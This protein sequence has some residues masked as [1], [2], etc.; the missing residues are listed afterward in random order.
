MK[1]SN[2]V[3][4][5][6]GAGA[7]G[8]DA[9]VNLVGIYLMFYLTDVLHLSP[10]FVGILFFAARIWDAV[11]DPVM[12]MIVDN[13]KSKYG[14]F[15]PWLVIG[16]LSNA[17]VFIL[18]FSQFSFTTGQ[19]YGYVAV[20]Y[21]LYGMTYTMMDIPYWSWL[22]NL[23]RDPQERESV[24]V[25]PRFFASLAGLLVGTFGLQV[26]DYFDGT[27]GNGDRSAGFT[28]FAIL[29]AIVFI[30][31]IGITVLNV[32]EKA[33]TN[34]TDSFKLKEI[35]TVLFKNKQLVAYIG[36]LLTFNLAMQVVNGVVLYYFT[37]V[38]GRESLFSIF[39]F[40]I[41]GEMT[42]LL[43]FPKLA[44]WLGRSKVYSIACT[45][46]GIGLMILLVG[47]YAAPHSVA[48]VALGSIILKFG[49]GLS[50]G[51][52]TVSIADV[53][54]YGELK[55]GKRSE[56]IITSTQ[57]FLMKTSQAFAG[58]LTGVGLDIAG[59]VPDAQQTAT[60]LFGIRLM[61]FG[62]PLFFAALSLVIYVKGYKLKGSKLNEMGTKLAVLQEE[63]AAA[64]A[65]EEEGTLPNEP[66]V[67][68]ESVHASK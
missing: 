28:A 33:T 37:Y 18:L 17:V 13:T 45:L 38:A 62:I 61:M 57:T 49:S 30:F 35:P 41:A 32:P 15:R 12:G 64:A 9:I 8:K 65:L 60:A 4:Y 23:T 40:A 68:A 19:L 10:G 11:N 51:V 5:S 16:T 48:L 24:S 39:N 21:I 6:F 58:L 43:L 26:I 3:K 50:L 47:G 52:T 27:F 1:L 54:D 56:S 34:S 20:M 59:Y 55:T 2:R 67:N 63:K 53:I 44:K 25:I 31:F 7:I 46:M 14:K 22:P 42:A 66:V 36:F 29:I